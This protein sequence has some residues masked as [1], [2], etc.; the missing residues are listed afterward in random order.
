[1][2]EWESASEPMVAKESKVI[3]NVDIKLQIEQS[4][5]FNHEIAKHASGK[6]YARTV[7]ELF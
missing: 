3:E 5:F 1:M 6:G 2:G 4:S 7:S